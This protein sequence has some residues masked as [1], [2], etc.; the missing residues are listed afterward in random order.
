ME[1]TG[2]NFR[3]A[4]EIQTML[5]R[6][7]CT[8]LQA[9]EILAYVGTQIKAESTVQLPGSGSDGTHGLN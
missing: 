6:E 8:V 7:H 3:I 1:A 9:T 2:R 5:A 4:G